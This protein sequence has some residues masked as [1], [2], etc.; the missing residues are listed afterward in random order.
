MLENVGFVKKNGSAYVKM[1][2]RK[3]CCELRCSGDIHLLPQLARYTNDH[4]PWSAEAFTDLLFQYAL[5]VC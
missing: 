5:A 4:L 2:L 3:L 1:L